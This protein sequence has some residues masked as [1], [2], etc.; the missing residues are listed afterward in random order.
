MNRRIDPKAAFDASERQLRQAL[1]NRGDKSAA[2]EM[3]TTFSVNRDIH[4]AL[5]LLAVR[6][7]C[8]LN[9]LVAIAVE[10]WIATQGSLPGDP[11]RADIRRRIAPATADQTTSSSVGET[12]SG[13]P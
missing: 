10:D 12:T 11:S 3:R 6:Y 9:D 8:K 7:R 13:R 2:A 4:D 1:R 5:R